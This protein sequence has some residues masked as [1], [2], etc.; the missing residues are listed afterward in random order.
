MS[1]P[2]QSKSARNIAAE[3]GTLAGH[4]A[5]EI[6]R[7]SEV[8]GLD[9]MARKLYGDKGNS[10]A[11]C[12]HR[13][14][15]GDVSLAEFAAVEPE[16]D[17]RVEEIFQ[18]TLAALIKNRDEGTLYGEDEKISAKTIAD[19]GKAGYWGLRVPKEYGGAGA[20]DVHFFRVITR[21][22][23]AGFHNEAGLASVHGCIGAVGPISLKGSEAQKQ[24]Y[25]TALASGEFTSCFALTELGAGSDLANVK[26]IARRVGDQWL[27]TG[28]KRFITGSGHGKLC[29]LVAC[30][31]GESNARGEMTK[32]V[33]IVELPDSDSESFELVRYKLHPLKHIP[34]NGLRFKNF[35]IPAENRL[36]PPGDNGM[37]TAYH[38]LNYGRIAVEANAAGAIRQ[39]LRSI[40]GSVS[41]AAILTAD[42]GTR[43]TASWGEFRHTLGR[44]IQRRDLV[45]ER[46]AR[47]ASLTVVCDAL[48]DWSASKLWSGFRGELECTM[49][50]V[51][52]SWAQEEAALKQGLLTHGGRSL[53]Q[54]HLIGDNIHDFLAALI[55]EGENHML[56]MK[57]FLEM[58]EQHG[59][60]YM[61][62]LGDGMNQLKKGDPRGLLTLARVLPAYGLWNVK[63]LLKVLAP[64]E[65]IRGFDPRLSRH[66][67]FALRQG[68][69]LAV[70]MNYYMVKHQVKLGD[71]QGRVIELSKDVLNAGLILVT[72]MHAQ[73]KGDE[74]TIA[75]A[76][77]FCTEARRELSGGR[78]T[79]AYFASCNKLADLVIAGNFAQLEGTHESPILWAYNAQNQPVNEARVKA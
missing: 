13:L 7:T 33:F 45:R 47:L 48:R 77:I 39:I 27:I 30:V 18:A 71:R 36:T 23:Q 2:Q 66:V 79:D 8:T 11:S 21:L 60:K 41:A 57:F 25:L 67:A 40:T 72:A 38:G 69:K 34:N 46:I 53:I 43:A 44:E 4:S 62:P 24:K 78:K 55:Y 1:N 26:T 63:A 58:G 51:F 76:D 65:T 54:G 3:V 28:E 14:L 75:A 16:F 74:A 68:K 49:A 50:K 22:S 5:D 17:P 19:L 29:C 20:A 52:G 15:W 37:V 42:E 56:L 32:A 10:S 59:E 64:T 61:I 73:R 9:A 12:I 31:E 6:A 35:A 70:K